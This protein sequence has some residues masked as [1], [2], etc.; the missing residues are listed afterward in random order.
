M[1]NEH[2]NDATA[3]NFGED[4]GALDADELDLTELDVAELDAAED[5]DFDS[6][7]ADEIII[8]DADAE[9]QAEAAAAV[10]QAAQSAGTE[11]DVMD[12]DIAASVEG[13]TKSIAELMSVIE[14]LVFVSDEPLTVKAIAEVLNEAK[15][16]VQMAVEGL[17]NELTERGSGLM[18]R[19]IAGGW[20]I[21][22]RPEHHEYIRSFLK[23]QP[24]AKLSLPGLETLAVIAYKQ[25]V[26]VPEIL[27]IR[28]VQSTSAIKTLLDKRLI[29][30][31]GRK[32]TVG[33]PMMYGTS[34]EFLMQFGLR[35]LSELPSIEDFEDLTSGAV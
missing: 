11:T 7:D 29:V 33:R 19:E 16:T 25:P 35:D 6:D 34:K 28:G 26:T 17:A 2:D 30:A 27:E 12:G 18:L 8:Y 1:Q 10:M 24:S 3:M 14:A 32:E 20:Q 23:S 31:K 13:E 4:T 22:T 15:D 9:D 21:T 5:D